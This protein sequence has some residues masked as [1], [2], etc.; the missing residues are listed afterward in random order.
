VNL[1]T[2]HSVFFIGIGGIG[3][4]ALAR[5]MHLLGKKVAGYD[6]VNSPITR[7]LEKQGIGVIYTDSLEAVSSD[8]K[9][10]STLVV[11]TPAIIIEDNKLL[12]YFNQTENILVKRAKLLGIITKNTISLAVAGTH[13]KTTTSSI[14]G[15]ILKENSIPATSFL[16]GIAENYNSNLIVGGYEYSVVEADEFD[17]SFLE[18]SPNFAC[19]TSMDADHLD[20]YNTKENLLE[21][22]VEFSKKTSEKL[23]VKKGLPIKGTTYA[24]EEEADY[25][26]H[27]V[28]INEGAFVFD[29]STP[30]ASLNNVKIHLP[31]RYNIEN[32]LA[33]L[34]MA[35]SIGVS[36]NGVVRALETYKGVHRRF[37][38]RMKT[39]DLVLIDDYAHHPTEIEAVYK[40][41][42]ELYPNEEIVVVFQ[43]HTFTRTR[44]FEMDFVKVLAQFDQVYLLPIYAAREHPIE[45]VSSNEL[46]IKIRKLNPNVEIIRE[47]ELV[48]VLHESHKK[49]ILML[50]AGDI[51][52]MVDIVK[53]SFENRFW[54]G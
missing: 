37:S 23:I 54:K 42:R 49:V 36:L 14:L 5:Y 12:S 44:D 24:V 38:F 47:I 32:T 3:M 30:E 15:H 8:F 18:L 20:V 35:D 31:G 39:E 10:N 48:S 25:R 7:E 4:S 17:R 9:T 2:I 27:N 46:V 53:K 52:L 51:G 22:F 43:P 28:R 6:K 40:A 13:G 1:K 50:G 45:G 34:A 29:V 41:V 19:I 16:G 11:Y 33:A 21:A 26:A